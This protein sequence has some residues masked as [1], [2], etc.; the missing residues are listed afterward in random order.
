MLWR[1]AVPDFSHAAARHHSLVLHAVPLF[2]TFASLAK[3]NNEGRLEEFG[4][5]FP[6][7]ACRLHNLAHVE[8]NA[9]DLAWDTVARFSNL[10]LDQASS[11]LPLQPVWQLLTGP[12]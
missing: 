8:L 3:T 1:V 10:Q 9:I 2:A 12:A 11:S 4:G 5:W 6:L 7:S